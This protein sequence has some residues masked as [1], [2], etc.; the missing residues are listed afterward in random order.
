MS[1]AAL[2][3]HPEVA[4]IAFTGSLPVG[5]EIVRA[6]AETGR[7]SATSSS[8]VAE[9]GGKNCVIVDSDADL[10]EAVPGDRRLGV[11]VRRARNARP[12]RGSS[13]TRRSPISC[14]SASRARS[15]CS[16]SARRTTLG[17]D[18][19]PVIERAAQERVD[20]YAELAARA[21]DDRR[22]RGSRPAAA[23]GSARRRSPPICPTD[24]PV[25]RGGDLRAA[26]R[27]SS[28]SATSSRRCDIVDG[29]PVRADR[30]AVRA[31]SR[32]G[33]ARPRAHSGREPVRQ[34]R[35]HR[36]RWSAASRSAA[37]GCRAPA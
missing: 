17:T 9:L 8:V 16:S 25:L 34:P 14:S 5:L 1:G 30:R 26:A 37:T 12:P 28:G 35:D 22:G 31:R 21:G 23:A 4:A 32:D 10:D 6:A 20:R 19:P 36:A 3:R 18:V 15:R 27:R 29:A 24:S 7:A 2:V 33:A 13:S 11:R